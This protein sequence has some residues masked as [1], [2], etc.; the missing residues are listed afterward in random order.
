MRVFAC[1]NLGIECGWNYSANTEELLADVVSVHLREAHGLQELSPDMIGRIK[2]AFSN[3]S[4]VDSGE[5][6]RLM[7]KEFTC[8]DLGIQ[9]GWHYIA[10]TEDLLADGV[11]VHAR[12]AHG[13]AEFTP[14]L[15]AKVKVLAHE[16]KG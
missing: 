14:E 9:C 8:H 10:Q 4:A 5:A 13:I 2:N 1:K 7:L 16:W 3:P 15:I 6:D 11:A 12:E